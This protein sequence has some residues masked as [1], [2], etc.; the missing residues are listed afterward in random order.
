MNP[1]A[2]QNNSAAGP[3]YRMSSWITNPRV[4]DPVDVL[5]RWF[6]S[7]I[8]CIIQGHSA[9]MDARPEGFDKHEYLIFMHSGTKEKSFSEC[10]WGFRLMWDLKNYISFFHWSWKSTHNVFARENGEI[11]HRGRDW[12]TK[13]RKRRKRGGCLDFY[14]KRNPQ[15][16]ESKRR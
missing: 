2:L 1:Y 6:L 11:T 7:T 14:T 10:F 12:K 16:G 13:P 15:P 8:L 5:F 3:I 9:D 4:H